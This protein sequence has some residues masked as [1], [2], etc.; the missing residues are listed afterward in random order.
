MNTGII[1]VQ[2]QEWRGYSAYEVAVRNG[3]TGTQ[4]EWLESLKGGELQLTVCG[5]GVD[6]EGNIVLYASD[7]KMKE[8]ALNTI[9]STLETLDKAKMPAD[10]AVD[11]L[12]S[13]DAKA[14]LSAN[15]GRVLREMAEN[16]DQRKTELQLWQIT[17][18]AQGWEGDGPWTVT[19]DVEGVTESCMA[20]LGPT[21]DGAENEEAFEDCEIKLVSKGEGT[22]TLRAGVRPEAAFTASL[23]L[24]VPGVME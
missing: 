14:P 23:A 6:A 12:D 20:V 1:R 7:I 3:F 8:G 9:A 4:K 19:M 18:P 17:I 13:E 15:Q 5:K 21:R 11:G 24:L 16:I 22:I 2:L 10:A